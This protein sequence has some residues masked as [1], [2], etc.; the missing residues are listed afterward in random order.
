LLAFG[1]VVRYLVD[2]L[3]A[4]LYQNQLI[5]TVREPERTRERTKYE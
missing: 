4:F 2:A 3:T 5:E 1:I